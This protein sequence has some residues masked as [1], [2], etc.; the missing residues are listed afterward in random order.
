MID[1][2]DYQ[3]I[4]LT[5][6]F[7]SSCDQNIVFTKLIQIEMKDKT[8]KDEAVNSHEK[9]ILWF[10][11]KSLILLSHTIKLNFPD[12]IVTKVDTIVIIIVTFLQLNM[13]RNQFV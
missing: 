6:D 11:T 12:I 9:L 7:P 2:S 3:I 1:N 8:K 4:D 13:M 5:S 10:P